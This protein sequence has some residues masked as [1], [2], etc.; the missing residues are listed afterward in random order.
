[1]PE[2]GLL[3]LSFNSDKLK[4]KIS[5]SFGSRYRSTRTGIIYNNEMDDFS[6]PGEENAYGVEPSESNMIQP[7]KRPQSS[8]AP[9]LFLDKDGVAR[10]VI[11]A[12]GGTKITTAISLVSNI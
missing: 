8:T 12:S 7:G 2:T 5:F 4:L 10:L 11:G 3:G 1:M 9:S 6:T